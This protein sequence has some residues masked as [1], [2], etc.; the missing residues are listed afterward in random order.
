LVAPATLQEPRSRHR[1]V[2]PDPIRWQDPK[3]NG[4]V[5][6]LPANRN[7]RS[8]RIAAAELLAGCG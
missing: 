3:R 1:P 4:A 8:G 2:T 6:R 5:T 7:Q